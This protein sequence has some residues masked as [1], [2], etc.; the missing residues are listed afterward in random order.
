MGRYSHVQGKGSVKYLNN[1]SLV[2]L[3][4]LMRLGTTNSQPLVGS[5]PESVILEELVL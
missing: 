2:V 4:G 5:A 3:C 1:W